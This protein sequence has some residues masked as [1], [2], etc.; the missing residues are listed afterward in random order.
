MENPEDFQRKREETLAVAEKKDKKIKKEK[1]VK[2]ATVPEEEVVDPLVPIY[3]HE[4]KFYYPLSA[5][6]EPELRERSIEETN[7]PLLKYQK[8]TDVSEIA[9]LRATADPAPEEIAKIITQYPAFKDT[10]YGKWYYPEPGF[11]VPDLIEPEETNLSIIKSDWV[12]FYD[13]DVKQRYIEVQNEDQFEH[14]RGQVRKDIETMERLERGEQGFEEEEVHIEDA[15]VI[16]W[17]PEKNR[18]YYP[19]EAL[20]EEDP[21]PRSIRKGAVPLVFDP[22]SEFFKHPQTDEDFVEVESEE[23][24]LEMRKKR[25]LELK[26]EVEESIP[27]F[28]PIYYNEKTGKSAGRG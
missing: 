1:G 21:A 14:M 15:D 22:V 16:Y 24:F 7:F 10:A 12:L 3:H 19:V 8:L 5:F 13:P 20:I 23:E 4:N 2:T 17:D 9:T 18:Y 27:E 25:Q 26:E 6:K 11:Q 28:A